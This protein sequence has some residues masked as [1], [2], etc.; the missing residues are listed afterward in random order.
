MQFL[1]EFDFTQPL[2]RFERLDAVG[3]DFKQIGWLYSGGYKYSEEHLQH[4]RHKSDYEEAGAVNLKVADLDSGPLGGP[5]L[6]FLVLTYGPECRKVF[7][8]CR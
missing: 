2:D 8:G 7:G 1:T 6:L 5:E 3:G 4:F